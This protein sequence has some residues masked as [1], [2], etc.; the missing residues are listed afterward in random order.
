MAYEW[1]PDQPCRVFE[2]FLPA[3][4]R[5]KLISVLDALLEK[6]EFARIPPVGKL[7]SDGHKLDDLFEDC[8]ACI[9]GYSIYEVEGRFFSKHRN[10]VDKEKSLVARL[11]VYDKSPFIGIDA[12]L[13]GKAKDICK[14]LITERLAVEIGEEDEIWLVTFAHPQLSRWVKVS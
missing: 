8:R 11:I 13:V 3:K 10:K 1:M 14:Y 6:D 2:V 4:H 9:S 5:E 7:V 12:N